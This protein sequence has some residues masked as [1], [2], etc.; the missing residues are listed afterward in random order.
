MY[1]LCACGFRLPLMTW[2]SLHEHLRPM[3]GPSHTSCVA[4]VL[5]I[6]PERKNIDCFTVEDFELEGYRPHKKIAMTMAV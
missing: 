5:R 3:R 4:Q 2:P 6:N 1:T